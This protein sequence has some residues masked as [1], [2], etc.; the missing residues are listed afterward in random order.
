VIFN[1][2]QIWHEEGFTIKIMKICNIE[3]ISAFQ[4]EDDRESGRMA[5]TLNLLE[6]SSESV[7]PKKAI[8]NKFKA[9]TNAEIS[10]LIGN[11][12]PRRSCKYNQK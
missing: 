2:F 11:F 3:E 5:P 1:K 8:F 10:R 4:E 7:V 6:V 12:Y 9:G